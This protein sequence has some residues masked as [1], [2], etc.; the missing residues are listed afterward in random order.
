MSGSLFFL[1]IAGFASFSNKILITG[2]NSA[3]C[4]RITQLYNASKNSAETE[5][6]YFDNAL[7]GGIYELVYDLKNVFGYRAFKV[8][9]DTN[10]GYSYHF[11]RDFFSDNPDADKVAFIKKCAFSPTVLQS[12]YERKKYNELIEYASAGPNNKYCRYYLAAAYLETNRPELCA[13]KI[14]TD[15]VFFLPL[16]AKYYA[17]TGNTDVAQK[18]YD[19]LVD[20]YPQ[21]VSYLFEYACFLSNIGKNEE[22]LSWFAKAAALEPDN[23][24]I[25]LNTGD[26]FSYLGKYDD[27]VKMYKKAIAI[28]P[29]DGYSWNNIGQAY[30]NMGEYQKAIPYYKEAYSRD[31]KNPVFN[32]NMGDILAKNGELKASVPYLKNTITYDS[33]FSPGWYTLGDVLFDLSEKNKGIE[34]LKKSVSIAPDSFRYHNTLA[35]RLYQLSQLDSADKYITIALKLAPDYSYSY[36]TLAEIEHAKGNTEMCFKSILK[37]CNLGYPIKEYINLYPFVLYKHKPELNAF[38]N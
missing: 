4:A 35:V 29:F 23:A 36:S 10:S 13:E 28:F 5:A 27:A 38:L 19:R 26:A 37:A 33:S 2:N 15:D 8:V 31:V 6:I 3:E 22:A 34:Y 17:R 20:V 12:L 7:A 21:N 30:D 11:H 16:S 18:L 1:T 25:W 9:I 14:S 24:E 32:Y